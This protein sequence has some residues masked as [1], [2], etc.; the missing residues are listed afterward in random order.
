MSLLQRRRPWGRARQ[1]AVAVIHPE[2][3]AVGDLS[4][5]RAPMN[6]QSPRT[7]AHPQAAAGDHQEKCL[8]VQRLWASQQR[9]QPAG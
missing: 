8:P 9:W 3:T 4:Q 5:S 6:Q 1:A 2:T 7:I